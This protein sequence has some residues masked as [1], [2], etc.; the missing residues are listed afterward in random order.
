ML[1]SAAIAANCDPHADEII[2]G[3]ANRRRRGYRCKQND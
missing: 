2:P 1:T 3:D